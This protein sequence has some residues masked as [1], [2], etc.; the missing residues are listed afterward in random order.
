MS[1]VK[2]SLVSRWLNLGLHYLIPQ[3]ENYQMF[4]ARQYSA[5]RKW[6]LKVNQSNFIFYFIVNRT[7]ENDIQLLSHLQISASQSLL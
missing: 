6:Q 1:R 4:R 2:L 7:L 3:G 5:V